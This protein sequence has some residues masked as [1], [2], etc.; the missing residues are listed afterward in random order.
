M[1]NSMFKWIVTAILLVILLILAVKAIELLLPFA[2]VA[3][4]AYLIFM[5]VTKNRRR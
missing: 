2:I 1:N 5:V 3:G 4:I